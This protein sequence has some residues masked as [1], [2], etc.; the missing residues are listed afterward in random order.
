M[1]A[2]GPP[3]SS[4]TAGC[5]S[6]APTAIS[7][8]RRPST[9]ASSI[10]L[11]AEPDMIAC[12]C[13][14][15]DCGPVPLGSDTSASPLAWQTHDI[16]LMLLGAR[17][18]GVPMIDRLGRRHRHQQPRRSLCRHHP[19]ARQRSTA[20]RSSSSAIS[21][22]KSRTR[23]W[24]AQRMRTS[25]V[26]GLDGRPDLTE[27]ELDAT[28]R[29][30]AVAGVHP[31]IKLLDMGADV[32]I[33]GRSSDCAIFAAPAIRNGYP[34]GARL[35]STARSWNAPRSAPSPMAARRAVHGRDH[36][37]GRAR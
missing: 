34:R 21:I 7:A 23:H 10:G 24:C 30:V 12:D 16:E 2:S 18:L 8:S 5:A 28:D 6:C 14:S 1:T 35:L 36:H 9:A 11:A 33:G 31:Y 19:R 22:R 15:S 29:I 25:A 26:R 17:R 20:C 27:A 32:I 37:G 3:I 13:G 4:P